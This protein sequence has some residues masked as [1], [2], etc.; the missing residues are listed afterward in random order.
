MTDYFHGGVAGL[1]V[2][3][4]L[5]PA[6]PHVTDGCPICVA[7]AE[8]RTYTVG[9]YRTYI[10]RAMLTQPR[11]VSALRQLLDMLEGEPDWAPLDPAT[12]QSDRVYLAAD[13]AY[14]RWYA[15]RSG[16]GD[17]YRVE[18]DPPVEQ[19]AG[20]DSGWTT[21]VALA[22]TVVEVLERNVRLT[23]PERRDLYEEWGRR[24]RKARAS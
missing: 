2:G 14:A 13:R 10:C 12:D 11:K 5:Y 20:E 21:F 7:R 19:T 18:P 16:N 22:A 3:D 24:D 4:R 15:A 6:A 9:E 17:L 8:G 1:N 23:P